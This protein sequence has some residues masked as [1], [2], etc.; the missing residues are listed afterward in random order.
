MDYSLTG[1]KFLV[2]RK[3]LAIAV[4]FF[5]EDDNR[6]KDDK[7]KAIRCIIRLVR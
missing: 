5:F 1:T 4:I 3:Y 6:M 2:T 7:I